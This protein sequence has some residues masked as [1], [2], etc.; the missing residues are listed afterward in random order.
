MPLCN[1]EPSDIF[2]PKDFSDVL[3]PEDYIIKEHFIEFGTLEGFSMQNIGRA[4]NNILDTKRG[5]AGYVRVL[6][7]NESPDAFPGLRISKRTDVGIAPHE[8]TASDTD[9]RS[10]RLAEYAIQASSLIDP[11]V[12]EDLILH[13]RAG[14][15]KTFTL[16]FVDA[17]SAQID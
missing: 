17:L 1:P 10:L 7:V 12:R 16:N 15:V 2:Q 6:R 5:V 13:T 11:E 8:W 9:Y 4:F 14:K 3:E